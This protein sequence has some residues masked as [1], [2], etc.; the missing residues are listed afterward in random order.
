VAQRDPERPHRAHH[1]M[2]GI[3]TQ[4]LVRVGLA[5]AIALE[6]DV[7]VSVDQA[8]Q[9]GAVAKVEELGIRRRRATHL[10]DPV[11]AA[12]D[13]TVRGHPAGADVEDPSGPEGDRP[14][15]TGA[16]TSRPRGR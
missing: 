5:A 10:L 2:G 11:T 12:D 7:G 15:G 13:H 9:E 3:L 16:G 6:Q 8:G 1:P 4:D 14:R